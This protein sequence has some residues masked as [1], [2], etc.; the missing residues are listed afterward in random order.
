MRL[1][2]RVVALASAGLAAGLAGCQTS[3][4]QVKFDDS[5]IAGMDESALTGVND[6][7]EQVTEAKANLE[8]ARTA[9]TD[10]E[11]SVALAESEKKGLEAE[12]EAAKV[13]AKAAKDRGEITST[14]EFPEVKEKETVVDAAKAKIDYLESLEETQK[15]E[16]KLHEKQVELA[17]AQ[18]DAAGFEA[19]QR[20]DP[21]QTRAMPQNAADFEARVA[22]SEAGV[23]DARASVAKHRAKAVTLYQDWL[24]AERQIGSADRQALA[25]PPTPESVGRTQERIAPEELQPAP[26]QPE[27]E[28]TE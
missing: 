27:E 18:V 11:K 25:P 19:L 17:E 10:L 15:A 9:Q 8:A 13:R 4:K 24:T 14:K 2:M 7:K 23:A 3:G 6:A 20:N 28:E 22:K 1:R 21:D 5:R 26:M 16:V 12:L